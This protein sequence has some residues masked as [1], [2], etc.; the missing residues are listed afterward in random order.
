MILT[1][2]QTDWL[3]DVLAKRAKLANEPDIKKKSPKLAKVILSI[4]KKVQAGPELK[5]SRVEMRTLQTLV[6]NHLDLMAGQLI[7]E[8]QARI[9]KNVNRKHYQAS[10]GVLTVVMK[11]LENLNNKI[12]EAL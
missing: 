1:A 10:L 9:D 6:G 2:S 5:L 3:I 4:Y 8:Y 11:E 7:P 12:A